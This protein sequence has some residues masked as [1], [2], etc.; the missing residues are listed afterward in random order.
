M[1]EPALEANSDP[2]AAH[3]DQLAV[4]LFAHRRSPP[5]LS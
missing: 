5:Y 3:L 2:V 4:A 1:G